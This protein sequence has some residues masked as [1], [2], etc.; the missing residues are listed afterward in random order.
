MLAKYQ[1]ALAFF[2]RRKWIVGTA[3]VATSM[4]LAILMKTTKTGFIPDE[5]TGTVFVSVTTAPG[6]TLNET[7]HVMEEVEKR[8]K[9]IA[10]IDIYSSVVGYNLMGGGQGSTAGTL[11]VRLKHWDERKGKGNDK[12]AVIKQIF[13]R[14][15]D[16]KKAQIYAFA[17]PM[18]MGY[19]TSNG[20]EIY[21]QGRKGGD[22]FS[23]SGNFLFVNIG[24]HSYSSVLVKQKAVI[25]TLLFQKFSRTLHSG[26][27]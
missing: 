9:E 1:Q 16:I 27:K 20:L 11:I 26:N 12:D 17:P 13:A 18:V 19:G 21:V 3:L 2:F 23:P 4:L 8:I 6:C 10:Q 15:S 25:G 7:K 24:H 5:D 14:T 22:R